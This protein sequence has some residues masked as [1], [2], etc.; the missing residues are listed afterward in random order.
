M[1]GAKEEVRPE[2][3]G[4][5][6]RGLKSMQDV[7]SY[8]PA[9]MDCHLESQGA[10]LKGT[11]KEG[12]PCARCNPDERKRGGGFPMN[13]QRIRWHR[14]KSSDFEGKGWP[15]TES[16]F[17]RMPP[18]IRE[19]LPNVWANS[20]SSTGMCVFFNT[21]TSAFHVKYKLGFPQIGEPN[22]NVS[23]FSGVDLYIYDTREK[24]WRWAAATL[25]NMVRDQNP[26]MTLIADLPSK[27]RKCRMYMPMR[28]QL[29]EISIG[30]D[31][32]ASFELV[33][34]RRK[35]PLVYYG[36]SIVH[37][38]YSTRAGLGIAQIL[39]RKLNMPLINLGFSG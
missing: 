21:D 19:S 9:V 1:D 37:G 39:A 29:L 11:L 33:P 27:K 38:A 26:Q 4:I 22:F 13:D 14:L 24:R 16:P 31:A 36:T 15:E 32:D 34:P 17:D 2:R 25:H 8:A 28:N 35:A 7:L 5:R 23:A 12:D 6:N 3:Y 20:H 18:K 30:V 10:H